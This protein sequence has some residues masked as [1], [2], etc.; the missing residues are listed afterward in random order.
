MKRLR[1]SKILKP[2]HPNAGI[3]AAYR[4]KLRA[5]VDDM[6]VSYKHW[7]L[8]SYRRNPPAIAQDALPSRE[9]EREVRNLGKRWK[10]KFNAAAPELAKYFATKVEK[11]SRA[12]LMKIL[13]DGGWTVQPS[14]FRNS[15]AARDVLGATI[16]ENVSLIKSIP[17]HFHTQIE[18]LVMRSVTTGRD[19][20]QL[21]RDLQKQFGVTRRRAEF[22]ARDQN[23]KAT[24]AITRVRY[25]DM[26]IQEAIWI[27]SLGGKEPR[28]THLAA[29]KRKQ[30][31]NV[32]EGWYDPD[33]KVK[34]H[35]QPGE[36][37]NCR[38]VCRPVVKGFS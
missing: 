3:H 34:R 27:H 38:C 13:K 1:G 21:T 10:S 19:L 8:A 11:R 35:I 18:G 25:M 12:T 36:L 30:R 20:A 22:I 37:N 5:L 14:F 24:A 31:F 26:G 28:K 29:G 32:A 6:L 15:E 33:P 9:L 23:N 16:A 2:I 7:I 4:K 17:E